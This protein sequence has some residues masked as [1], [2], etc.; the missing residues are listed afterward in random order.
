M[1]V[2]YIQE[3]HTIEKNRSHLIGTSVGPNPQNENNALEFFK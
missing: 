1:R 2:Y 3:R